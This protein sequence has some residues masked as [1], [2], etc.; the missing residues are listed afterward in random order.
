MVY[1]IDDPT[2]VSSPPAV[3]SAS[4]LTPGYFTSGN[5]AAA[6]PATLVPDWWLNMVQGELLA[7]VVSAGLNPDKTNNGQLL[8]AIQALAKAAAAA[9]VA[10]Y[11]TTEALNTGLALATSSLIA[12]DSSTTIIVPAGVTRIYIE[13]K[14]AGGGG[15]GCQ[16]SNN[17]ETFSGAGGG[18]G[19]FM[20]GVY[21]VTPGDTLT[22]T[23]GSGGAG[24]YAAGSGYQGSTSKIVNGA[25]QVLQSLPGAQGGQYANISNTSG[26]AG[27][28]AGSSDLPGTFQNDVGNDGFDGQAGTQQLTGAGGIGPGGLGGARAGLAGGVSG[29]APGAGGGGAYDSNFTGDAFPGGNGG[30]GSIKYKW[31][32]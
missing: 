8:Q 18:G 3:P 6:I 2:A 13:G 21:A 14:G 16:A 25:G 31:L 26:G 20:R 1:R 15:S 12:V 32:P 28:I 22:V 30:N 29:Q 19:G 27:A 4:G 24:F 5:P 17:A 7:P 23:I 11:A 10:S 9:A